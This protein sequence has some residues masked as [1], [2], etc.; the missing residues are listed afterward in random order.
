MTVRRDARPVKHAGRD[1]RRRDDNEREIV[2]ALTL[3]GAS[4]T[5]LSIPGGPDLLVGFR[6]RTFLLEVKSK[7]GKLNEVQVTWH[8]GW[9]G[10]DV[11]VVRSPDEALRLIGVL[12]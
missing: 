4:V 7:R 8:D 6:R 2:K 10:G 5:L 3:C 1:G 9:R 11:A 12:A